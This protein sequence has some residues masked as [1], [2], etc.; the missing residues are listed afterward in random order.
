MFL[1]HLIN[2]STQDFLIALRTCS[3]Y[4]CQIYEFEE[5]MKRRE[6]MKRIRI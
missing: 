6:L 4:A 3:Y 5:K 2:D 1:F